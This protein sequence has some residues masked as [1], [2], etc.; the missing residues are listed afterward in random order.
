[1]A[2]LKSVELQL[3]GVEDLALIGG[4][5]SIW[6]VVPLRW[7]DLA[8]LLWWLFVPADRKAGVTLTLGG[9]SKVSFKAVRVATRHVRVRGL[10]R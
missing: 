8:T 4:D 5:D 7:W 9:G 10:Y 3:A 6:L 1:M 2:S